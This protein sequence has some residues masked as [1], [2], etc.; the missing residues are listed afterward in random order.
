MSEIEIPKAYEPKLTED[1]IY[2]KWEESGFFNPDNLTGT[3]EPFVISMPPP[4]AT[5]ILHLGHASML[6]YQDLMIR[7]ARMQGKKALWIPGTDHA[8]IATQ[9]KV[10]QLLAKDKLKKEDLGRKKFI[11]K[12]EEFVASSRS[13]IKNQVKKMG[14]SCDWSRERYTLDEGL[15]IAVSEIFTRMY[16]DKLIYKGN[17]IVNWCPCCQSTL[18][19]DEVEHKEQTAKLYTFK[20]N[21]NFPF[22][23]ATTRPETKLGD[24]AIAVNP[25][26]ER[27][28]KFIGQTFAVDFLGQKLNLKIIADEQVDM[29]FGTGALGVTPA[30]SLIDFEMAQKNNLPII[31]IINEK[32][33]ITGRAEKY[34]GLTVKECKEKIVADLEQAGLIEKVEEIK[35][36]LAI[37][38]RCDTAIEPL[39]SEQWFIAVNKKITIAN[40]PLFQNKSLKEVAIEV[41]KDEKI[42]ILPDRF[43]KTYFHWMNNLNDWCISRQIWWGHRIPVWYKKEDKKQKRE[44][45]FRNKQIFELI[46]EGKKNIETRALNPEEQDRYFGD[47]KKGDQLIF[48][49]IENDTTKEQLL[50]EIQDARIY[51]NEDDFFVKENVNNILPGKTKEDIKTF[52]KSIN[53]YGEKIKQ[54]GIIALEIKNVNQI[55][56]N[57]NIF[58]DIQ[59]PSENGWVQDEDTLDVWFSSG[60]WTFSTLGWPEKTKDLETFHPTTVMETGYDILFFWV[61]R[62]IIMTT[63]AL[64][65]IPFK[66]VYLHGLIRDEKGRKMSKSL[67]NGIDPLDM[68]D[69][70]GTDA[71][72]MSMI[73]GC[74]AGSDMNLGE[75][76][77]EGYRNFTNKLWNISRYI[78]MNFEFR[79]LNFELNDKKLTLADKWILSGLNNL[80][81]ETT[82]HLDKYEFSLAGEKIRTF[83]W[84]DFADWYIEICKI[85]KDKDEI[86]FYVLTTVLKLLHPFMPF[87][88]EEIWSK[89]NTEK[90]LMITKWPETESRIMNLESSKEFEK[91]KELIT[92]VRTARAE[93]KIE[94]AKKIN[95][96]IYAGNDTEM[97]SSQSEIIKRLA[98]IENLEIKTTGEKPNQAIAIVVGTIEIYLPL[99]DLL[100]LELEKKRITDEIEQTKKYIKQIEE[101]LNNEEFVK[102]APEKIVAQEKEKMQSSKEKLEKLENSLKSIL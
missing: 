19:D 6:A 34:Q 37:C 14:S 74:S 41:V 97:I 51:K 77:I 94:P 4:N 55:K 50:V 99:A 98:R 54:N 12:V 84:D 52:W 70:Y 16:N 3:T 30:H 35:N 62:M 28:Q 46:K 45:N 72:R 11:E 60:L 36:N 102:N 43:N 21:K 8:G 69:K 56:N 38:Y 78:L 25:N 9:V 82:N 75:S 92:S 63:Y 31:Q 61:A 40:N 86:L 68:I 58:V 5:G 2:Q 1:K 10:E 96:I 91:I 76:K 80:I 64:G 66:N 27:Y 42:N 44:L 23:I 90:L 39:I 48:N 101:K 53:G 49:Y 26:D 7:Y 88:T 100:D 15:S 71:L 22:T 13:T 95:A 81:L 18:S 67:G 87:V 73:I 89:I 24:T 83:V 47:I 29:T 79:I 59:P 33:F 93:N 17:R 20:Y 57:Q 85:E 65:E 32:N